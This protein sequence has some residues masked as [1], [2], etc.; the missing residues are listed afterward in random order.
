MNNDIKIGMLPYALR[1][2]NVIE[3]AFELKEKNDE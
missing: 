3:K 2:Q 1:V